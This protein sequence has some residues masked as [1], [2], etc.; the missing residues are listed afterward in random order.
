[1]PNILLP[2]DQASWD[3]VCQHHPICYVSGLDDL[4]AGRRKFDHS[5]FKSIAEPFREMH[6]RVG[7]VYAILCTHPDEDALLYIGS[8]QPF[9]HTLLTFNWLMA[10]RNPRQR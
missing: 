9:N 4:L 7:G 10:L 5:F 3:K 2:F 1:M 6:K 8:G